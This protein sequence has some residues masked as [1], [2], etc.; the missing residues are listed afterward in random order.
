MTDWEPA[1]EAEAAMREALRKE[2][3]EAYFQVLARTE[4]LLPVSGDAP[5][6]GPPSWGTWT[7][8]GRT[9]VL[10]FTSAAA[11]AACLAQH[12]GSTRHVA[13]RDLASGWP[14][15]DWWLAVNPGLSIEGYL[16]AWFV[17][18][19]ASGDVRLPGR[20]MGARARLMKADSANRARAT[21][22][23]PGMTRPSEDEVA[24]ALAAPGASHSPGTLSGNGLITSSEAPASPEAEAAPAADFSGPSRWAAAPASTPPSRPEPESPAALL[25]P[26]IGPDGLPRRPAGGDAKPGE[27]TPAVRPTPV[28]PLAPPGSPGSPASSGG[29]PVLPGGPAPAAEEGTFA[30]RP[31]GVEPLP[32][33]PTETFGPNGDNTPPRYGARS[34][35][36]DAFPPRAEGDGLP[37]RP[38][39]GAPGA[40]SQADAPAADTRPPGFAPL[41]PAGALPSRPA[42][43][44]PA[45]SG[46][47]P[48]R[49]GGGDP[50]RPE[51]GAPAPFRPAGYDPLTTRAD[52]PRPDG[53]GLPQ[54]PEPGGFSP[55]PDAG[56]F[57]SRPEAGG[58]LPQ[59]PEPGGFP[60]PSEAGGFPQRAE[61]G[62]FAGRPESNG[63]SPRPEF[64]GL[65]QRPDAGGLPARPDTNGLSARPDI[66]GFPE[67]SGN[68]F[69]ERSGA[70]SSLEPLPKRPP[71]GE[72]L[73][74]R[75]SAADALGSRSSAADALGSR[76]S[77]ADALGSRP[78]AA[79]ALGAR[80]SAAD[81]LGSRSSAADALGSRPA[82]GSGPSADPLTA[83]SAA[84]GGLPSRPVPASPAGP[85]PDAL[86][87][88]GFDS[89][90]SRPGAE[91]LPTRPGGDALTGRPGNDPSPAWPGADPVPSRSGTDALPSRPSEDAVPSRPGSDAFPS[92]PGAEALP[93]RPGAD[94][95]PSRPTSPAPGAPASEGTEA[96]A[97]D[98]APAVGPGGLPRRQASS[99]PTVY[100]GAVPVEEATDY[101]RG[102]TQPSPAPAEQRA[103]HVWAAPGEAPA[104]GAGAPAY[105]SAQPDAGYTPDPDRPFSP[106]PTPAYRPESQS[107]P[108][109]DL[110]GFVP[111]NE[112]EEELLAAAGDG[113]TDSFLSTLLL[114]RVMLPL[115]PGTSASG[116]RPGD[117]DFAWRTDMLDGERYVVVYTS[118]ER[119]AEHLFGGEA[120]ETVS[121]KFA[122]LIRH[123]PDPGL[124]F[125]VNPGSP[126]GATLP[127]S[128]IVALASW[129]KEVGL[130]EESEP[131]EFVEPTPEPVRVAETPAPVSRPPDPNTPTVMQK[132]VSPEQVDYFLNRGYDRVSGFLHRANEVEHLSTPGQLLAALGLLYPGSPF[133]SDA[134][135]VHVLRWPAYRPTLYRIPYGG[136]N[137]NAMRAMEGWVIERPPFRGNGFAPGDSSDVIAE[138]K[139]DSVRLPHGS[140]LWIMDRSGRQTLLA[141]LDT[142]AMTWRKVGEN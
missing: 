79:D 92:R 45:A 89:P 11:L 31:G 37:R 46:G 76:S 90:L 123:W 142:D 129:A 13:Y 136:Q 42:P 116:G 110:A 96:S 112:V 80:S 25:A 125:A 99:T 22:S 51:N 44:D 132:A 86:S 10:A 43:S 84:S 26:A 131:E 15:E 4:L 9:H 111:A 21:A 135:S 72:S 32:T 93:S 66:N 73:P 64:G 7:T 3:Q 94:P 67:R 121:V 39:P 2:D 115:K 82:F 36:A 75:P 122:H 1:T 69:P 35:A 137:E 104:Y 101:L 88:P 130:G 47:F 14:N 59:R 114:A 106:A 40:R 6:G 70:D 29:F 17:A 134:D 62:A 113:S 28:T 24:A 57:P 8:G 49:P 124:S 20:T 140:E 85:G 139:V 18:Q 54:R 65:P 33:R 127:G 23:V 5:A 48:V 117:P 138:F 63:V 68:G 50:P 95:L 34:G 30:S 87:R 16:P 108:P 27:A 105:A 103:P 81:A 141:L 83:G 56:G 97:A 60:A 133:R 52:A 100:G 38:L 71:N 98:E 118:A 102:S 12:A 91:P 74:K 126:V 120:I 19:L 61:S 53:N 78:S 109:P 77:A 107:A 58:G 119:L 128:Q 41:P 55:R